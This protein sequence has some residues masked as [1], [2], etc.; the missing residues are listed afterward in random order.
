M[1]MGVPLVIYHP[2][3]ERW[4]IFPF[5][6][7]IQRTGDSLMTMETLKYEWLVVWN[8]NFI[9]PYIGFMSSSQLTNSYFSEGW[10][11]PTNQMS[12]GFQECD[13]IV[14]MNFVAAGCDQT[15]GA[16]QTEWHPIGS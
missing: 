14:P 10:P 5:T 9:F 15:A 12:G 11:W 2:S 13:V 16:I 6:K 1:A 3:I 7:T 4:M 8:I